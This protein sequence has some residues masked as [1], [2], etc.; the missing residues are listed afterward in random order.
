MFHVEH[1]G[2]QKA[3]KAYGKRKGGTIL[4]KKKRKSA[5]FKILTCLR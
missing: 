1:R 3:K 5:I 2:K 4:N